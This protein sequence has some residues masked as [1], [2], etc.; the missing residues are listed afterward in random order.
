M[1][2]AVGSE[3]GRKSKDALSS[4]QPPRH[5]LWIAGERERRCRWAS[6][7][8]MRLSLTVT[9]IVLQE[10]L[11]GPWMAAS[12]LAQTYQGFGSQTSGGSGKP[13][14]RVTTLNDSGAG[15][16]RDAVSQGNRYIVF[17]KGGEIRLSQDIWVGGANITIDGTTAP[18]PGITLKDHGLVISGSR[19]ARD[20]ILSGLRVR[21][22]KGC[23]SCS[24]TGGGVLVTMN[25][26]NIVIDRVSVEGSQNFSI[27]VSKGAR[28]VTIQWSILADNSLLSLI[29]GTQ[30]SVTRRVT[31]HHNLLIKGYE[32]MPQAKWSDTG[33][34]ATDTQL[35]FRNNIVW[36]WG[37]SGTQIWKGTRANIVSNYFHDPNA[38]DGGKRRAIYICHARSQSP[39]CQT[40]NSSLY[41]RAYIRGNVSGHGPAIT[42]YLNS[43]GTESSPFSAQSVSTSDACTAAQQVLNSA[44]LRPLDSVDKALLS[45]VSLA[46]CNATYA[47]SLD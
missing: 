42:D 6:R 39:N 23:D 3:V 19:G 11:G 28:D 40:S 10:G 27:S 35:D 34:Q 20:I 13:V 41:A 24:T 37:Y 45:L 30:S 5:P 32:R 26:Y 21:N 18:S 17:D 9:L 43:L 15:S 4:V 38:S 12:A 2:F 31:M 47:S 16:L 7:L 33:A 29:S 44:G 25:A 46:P 8:L 36:D 22:S 14:Y 1:S